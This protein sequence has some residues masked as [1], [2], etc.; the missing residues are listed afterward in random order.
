MRRLWVTGYRAYELN[1]FKD[2]ELKVEVIKDVL[3]KILVEKLNETT[4]SFWLLTGPN[5]GVDQWAAQVGLSLKKDYRQLKVAIMAPYEHF[6]QQ[7]NDANQ[8]KLSRLSQS[9]DFAS[10]VTKGPYQSPAQLRAYTDFMVNYSDEAV[11][12]YDPD[13]QGKPQWDYA[14]MKRAGEQANYPVRVVDFDELQTAAD[15]WEER[16][17]EQETSENNDY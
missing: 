10:A 11:I 9:V 4:E 6:G 15:E 5:L 3:N 2:D 14:A 7:W 17:R 16:R 12:I 13:Q 1:V 8:A